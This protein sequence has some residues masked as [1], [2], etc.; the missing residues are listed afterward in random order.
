MTAQAAPAFAN[1]GFE[2][3]PSTGWD[4]MDATNTPGWTLV[5]GTGNAFPRLNLDQANR[6]PYGDNNEDKQFATIGGGEDG[7]TSALEQ[8]LNGFS[9]GSS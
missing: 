7:G 5:F 3:G 8:V 2:A 9:I 6:G 1:G 4:L